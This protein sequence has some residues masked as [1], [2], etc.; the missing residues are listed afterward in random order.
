M[1]TYATFDPAELAIPQMHQLLVGGVG[2]RPVCFASTVDAE[3]RAN[4]APFSFFN[5]FSANP[6]VL[7]FSPANSGRDAS[8]KHSYLNAKA[9]PEVV[10]NIVTEEM[11]Q[12]MNVAAA[13]W[14]K[15]VS[16]FEMAGF[17]PL[18]SE[19]V[20]P[21]RVAESP[22]QYECKVMEVKELGTGG[23]S[24]NLII[25][26]VVRVHVNSSVMTEDG[27]I[28]QTALHTVG[29]LGGH[30]YSRTGEEHMFELAQPMQNPIGY[31]GLPEAVKNSTE[32]SAYEMGQLAHA[33]AAPSVD[34]TS[35]AI[36]EYGP[37]NA[38]TIK[39]LLAKGQLEAALALAWAL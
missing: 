18:A 21:A 27:R 20:K 24:G 22:V 6:P 36:S 4:L 33:M 8:P 12:K 34:D 32:L 16:E 28:N 31:A 17:T 23:G 39:K 2:P 35:K 13:P 9:H 11:V 29:R 30:W 15:G 10:I 5:V 37:S 14:E 26:Q 25:C 1:T 38:A 3:G 7:I 19:I